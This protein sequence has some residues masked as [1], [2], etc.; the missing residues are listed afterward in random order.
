MIQSKHTS[1]SA[2][3]PKPPKRRSRFAP[4]LFA[5]SALAASLLAPVANAQDRHRHGH[6]DSHQRNYGRVINVRPVYSHHVVREPHLQCHSN[7]RHNG[8]HSGHSNNRYSSRG[9]ST[10]AAPIVGG[11]IGGAIGNAIAGGHRPGRAISSGHRNGQA[12]AARIGATVAGAI[13]GAAVGSEIAR[14]NN[15]ARHSSRARDRHNSRH[16]VG[17][18]GRHCVEVYESRRERRLDHYKVTYVHQGRR[19]TMTTQHKPG[20]RIRIHRPARSHKR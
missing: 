15:G 1:R 11:I 10:G 8:R 3:Q 2:Q 4:R 20:N 16:S 5:F 18:G 9:H 6:H 14:N 19:F 13:I 17:R 12:D 7:G